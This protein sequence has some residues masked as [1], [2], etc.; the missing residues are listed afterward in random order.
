M[1]F[2]YYSLAV[3][4]ALLGIVGAVLPVLPG[5]ILS[6]LGLFFLSVGSVV[7][8]L[9]LWVWG[10]VCGVVMVADYLLPAYMT[11]RLGG[12][13]AGVTGA[14]IGMIAGFFFPP[15]GIFLGPFVG[16]VM[17][18]LTQDKSKVEHAFKVGFGS[19]AAFAVGT[20]VKFVYAIFAL[21]SVLQIVWPKFGNIFS[22]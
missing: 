17:G 13:K 21:S 16:A 2:V 6:L 14:T 1:D 9:N 10:F 22:W 7:V 15:F 8:D 11:K 20:G 4:F 3:I 5:P 19:F 12:S 18:E